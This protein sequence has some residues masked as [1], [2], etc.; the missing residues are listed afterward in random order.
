MVESLQLA[1]VTEDELL[2]RLTATEME[3]LDKFLLS[4]S[5]W[6][7]GTVTQEVP[8]PEELADKGSIREGFRME[9]P[10]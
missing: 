3:G 5:S 8:L 7:A 9:S 10:D 4:A 2:A 1:D 6:W